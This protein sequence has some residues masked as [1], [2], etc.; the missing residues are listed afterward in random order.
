M[1]FLAKSSNFIIGPIA[2][3]F[4]YLMDVLFKFTGLFGVKNI[5][6]CIILFTVVTKLLLMPLT[7]KQQRFSRLSSLMNPELMEIANKYRGKND[8]ESMLAMREEQKRI[9]DKYGTSQSAGCLQLFIQIP[10]IFA[11]Y[12]VIR[13]IPSYV[14]TV[15]NHFKNIVSGES[16][17]K[18]LRDNLSVITSYSGNV[19]DKVEALTKTTNY[20]KLV[21]TLNSFNTKDWNNL[22]EI[23]D[24][25]EIG[26][27]IAEN[28]NEI[29]EMNKFFGMNLA[30]N[31]TFNSISVLIPLLSGLS[32]FISV[33][34]SQVQTA[35][36]Q[37]KIKAPENNVMQTTMYFLPV[38]SAIMC[39]GF[40]VG[41]GIYW[42]AQSV[43]Q[44][45][46]Q[47]AVNHYLDKQ[48]I[49]EF[50]ANN[51]EKAKEKRARKGLPE[52]VNKT[53]DS[54]IKKKANLRVNEKAVDYSEKAGTIAKKAAMVQKYNESHKNK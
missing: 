34:I 11:L 17:V 33:K 42:V 14:P 16:G 41:I 7:I 46:I 36:K 29:I 13:N 40:P 24:G 4:G 54:S 1:L 53:S 28:A 47:L 31:P 19:N 30:N 23:F 15:G 51:L 48:D 9:Y 8:N 2:I 32:Q 18:G 39:F 26:G 37:G 6:L 27:I 50:I 20:D 35:K 45:I 12:N 21:D 3:L 49:N 22:I 10:I 52:V 43:I 38:M 44:I 25:K 5:G